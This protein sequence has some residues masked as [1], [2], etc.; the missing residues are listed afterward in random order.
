MLEAGF[1]PRKVKNHVK[2]TVRDKFGKIKQE[3]ETTNLRTTAGI[4]WVADV[5]ADSGAQ[6]AAADYIAVSD[7]NTA[8]VVGDTTLA[9]ELAVDGLSRAQGTYAHT[10]GVT[11]YTVEETFTVTGGPHTVYKAALFNAAA[12]GTM[13]FAALFASAAIVNASDT[14]TVTWTINI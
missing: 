5:L 13:P 6:P 14:L 8:P 10:A 1:N 3:L 11:S 9:S 12:A 2:M 7:D 4:D